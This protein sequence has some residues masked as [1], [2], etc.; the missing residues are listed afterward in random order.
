M[1]EIKFRA[2]WKHWFNVKNNEMIYNWE[3]SREMEDVWFNWWEY[4][5]IMQYIWLKDKNWKEIYEGDILECDNIL[6]EV[7][8]KEWTFYWYVEWEEE[9]AMLWWYH[10]LSYW[11]FDIEEVK[12]KGNIF[13]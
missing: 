11:A 3:N 6:Y 7:Q 5:K 9:L 1:R 10:S 2:Y 4:Y 12:I 13:H 8:F